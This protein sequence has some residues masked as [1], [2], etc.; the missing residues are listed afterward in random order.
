[1]SSVT[2]LRHINFHKKRFR[3]NLKKKV[4]ETPELNFSGIDGYIFF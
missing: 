4:P 2:M 1:M 3:D